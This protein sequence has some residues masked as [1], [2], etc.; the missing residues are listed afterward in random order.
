MASTREPI[1]FDATVNQVKTLA[2]GGLRVTLDLPEHAIAQAAKLMEFKRMEMPL[3]VAVAV[4]D[5]DTGDR[6][7]TI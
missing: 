3:R 2:D 5:D 4:S 7:D 1:C 6:D